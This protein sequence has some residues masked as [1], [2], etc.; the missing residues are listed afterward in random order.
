MNLD[1]VFEEVL[2][3]EAQFKNFKTYDK[4]LKKSIEIKITDLYTIIK[5][6]KIKG[7]KSKSNFNMISRSFYFFPDGKFDG[8]DSELSRLKEEKKYKKLGVVR[9]FKDK[10]RITG[11]N[12]QIKKESTK[13]FISFNNIRYYFNNGGKFLERV[14]K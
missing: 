1:S 5:I 2:L 11:I 3:E 10:D 9:D 4:D 7:I 6:G 12:I 8:T 13:Y 14:A